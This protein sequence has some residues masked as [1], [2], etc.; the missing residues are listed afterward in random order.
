MR[1]QPALARRIAAEGHTLACHTFPIRGR[2][3]SAAPPPARKTSS[4]VQGHRGYAGREAAPFFRYPGFAD[5]SLLNAWLAERNVGVFGCDLWASDWT[6]MAPE[7]QLALVTGRLR[8]ARRGIVLFHDTQGQTAAMLPPPGRLGHEGYRL[9]HT[10]RRVGPHRHLAR[11]ARLVE[12]HGANDRHSPRPGPG[13]SR[14]HIRRDRICDS[15][16]AWS[17]QMREPIWAPMASL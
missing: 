15:V 4:P 10:R 12:R 17:G 9:A 13:M 11:P 8:R 5:T 16:R 3:A 7:T 6:P 2:C 1:A 14:P